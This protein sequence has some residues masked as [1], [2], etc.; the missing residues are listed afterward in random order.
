MAIKTYNPT[1]PGRRGM[2]NQ[3]FSSITAKKPLKKLLV[4]KKGPVG[5]NNTGRITVRHR[6]AGARRY[7]RLVNF[8]LP[9]GT[10]ASVE[11]IEYDPN[12]SAHIARVKDQSGELHYILAAKGMRKGNKLVVEE[13]A[14]V[15]R[16]NRM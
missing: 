16:G 2:T 10:T 1:T 14:S 11:E 15:E 4:I 12:R 6:G 5:R 7:Y 9:V 8:N 3:D 13:E